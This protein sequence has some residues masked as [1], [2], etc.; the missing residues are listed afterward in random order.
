M[1]SHPVSL[2]ILAAA[3]AVSLALPGCDSDDGGTDTT[4]ADN[5]PDNGSE[6]GSDIDDHGE[7]FTL[8]VSGSGFT[9]HEGQTLVVGFLEAG[10][11]SAKETRTATVA[12]GVFSVSFAGVLEAGRAY[13]VK[14]YADVDGDGKCD[15]P[16]ADHA[17]SVAVPAVT[18]NTH[19]QVTHNTDFDSTACGVF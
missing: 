12:G 14:Y 8:A 10:D 17:W 19:V 2:G 5:S 3:A 18:E 13:T 6:N 7:K 16:P 9:P 4:M 15:T 1:R 11:D